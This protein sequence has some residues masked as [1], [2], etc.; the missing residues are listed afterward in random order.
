MTLEPHLTT[1]SER[2]RAP[3]TSRPTPATRPIT[4]R[5]KRTVYIPFVRLFLPRPA[6]PTRSHGLYRAVQVRRRPT[7]APPPGDA[8][9]HVGA[10]G[11]AIAAVPTAG[12]HAGE[13]RAGD[14]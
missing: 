13:G 4:M 5:Y 12:R 7:G 2:F 6:Y 3:T 10:P 1:L 8:T 14:P 11:G 9:Q